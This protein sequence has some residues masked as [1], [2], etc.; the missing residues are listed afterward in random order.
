[1]CTLKVDVLCKLRMSPYAWRAAGKKLVLLFLRC[2][3][4]DLE[5]YNGISDKMN[6]I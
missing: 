5:T 6:I 4:F 3:L 2:D 1:M